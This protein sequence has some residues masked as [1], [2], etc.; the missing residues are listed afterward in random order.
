VEETRVSDPQVRATDL[1]D[2]DLRRLALG[3]LFPGFDGTSPPPWLL[4]LVA[5][6]LAGVVLFERN[7]VEDDPDAGAARITRA[8]RR[9]RRGVLVAIDEE[10]GDVSRLDVGTGSVLPGAAALGVVDDEDLTGRVAQGLG[11]RLHEAGVGINLSPVADVHVDP[12]NPV[13]GIR[14]FGSDVGL[15]ARHVAAFVAGQQAQRVAATVKHFPGHGATREDSHVTVPVV[16]AAREVLDARDLV[17]FRAAITAGVQVVMTAHVRY[18]ALDEVPATLSRRILTDLLRGE[19]GFDGVVM[20]DGLDMHAIS[21]TVGHAEGAVLAL[22]A[23]V[24]ALCVGGDSTEPE[25]VEMLVTAITGAVRAGRLPLPRLRDAARRVAALSD[26]VAQPSLAPPAPMPGREAAERALRVRGCVAL[27]AP[28]VVVELHDEPSRVG[29]DGP[30]GVGA[31][32]AARMPGTDV[33]TLTAHDADVTPVLVAATGRPLVVSVRGLSRRRWQRQVL[34]ALRQHRPDLVVV[35]H[36]LPGDLHLLGDRYVLTHG[37]SRVSAEAAAD[38]LA[39][40]VAALDE[41]A[42]GPA[43]ERW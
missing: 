26:W 17:P 39:D 13:I 15:V 8:L 11:T 32:L 36:G 19:L 29:V 6:G 41:D 4:D 2:D 35:D 1:S 21:R 37:G 34:V 28:P 7:I 5:V 20:S 31:P 30:W 16:H 14:S 38:L 18:P 25:M 40:P 3:V 24:D 22:T 10:G 27:A 33:V 12:L 43:P 42:A 23:G 9:A